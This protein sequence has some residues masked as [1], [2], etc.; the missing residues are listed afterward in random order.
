[1]GEVQANLR[2]LPLPGLESLQMSRKCDRWPN[3]AG[4][5]HGVQWGWMPKSLSS[6]WSIWCSTSQLRAGVAELGTN[7]WPCWQ[8]FPGRCQLWDAGQGKRKGWQVVCNPRFCEGW[9]RLKGSCA[10]REMTLMEDVGNAATHNP[11]WTDN[12]WPWFHFYCFNGITLIIYRK[13]GS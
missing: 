1:M 11:W 12:A 6:C 3:P 8:S 13:W 9:G 4:H 5:I 7:C 10:W 2:A